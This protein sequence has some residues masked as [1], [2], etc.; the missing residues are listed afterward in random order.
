MSRIRKGPTTPGFRVYR[1]RAGQYRWR[2]VS[3]NGQIVAT[4]GE[5]YTRRVDCVRA[6]EAVKALVKG[7]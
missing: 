3:G 2:L 1:D 5:G 7:L 6:V 4:P